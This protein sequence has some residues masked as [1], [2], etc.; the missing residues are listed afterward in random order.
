MRVLLSGAGGLI[1]RTLDDA[2]GGRGD[3]V[4]RLVRPG[5][6]ADGVPWDPTGGT[7]DQVALR[8]RGPYDAVVNLA[9]AGI[10]DR[11]WSE[12]RQREI[13]DSRRLGTLALS[14]AM[15]SLDPTPSVLVNASAV[16][17][18]GDGGDRELSEADPRGAGFLADVCDAWEAATVPARDAGVRTVCVRSGI[19]LSAG[20]GAMGRLLPLFRLGLGGRLG[21]GNQWMSWI[22]LRDE[23]AVL[24]RALDDPDLTG[25]V[26]AVA[27]APVTNAAFTA[28]L[29]RVLH[30]PAVLAVPG[31]ALR[32]AMGRMADEMLLAGQRVRPRVL[33]AAGHRFEDPELEGA[34]EGLLHPVP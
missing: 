7:V 15:A 18:Y 8:R 26:N 32:A 10:G 19:V 28:T 2:L 5:S 30:R 22:T 16:G 13:L 29:A 9:G 1:G 31:W 12:G 3:E 17:F 11:R 23:V 33:E 14:E 21:G 25:P 4:V 6:S 20:G 24:C 34:L 27:P